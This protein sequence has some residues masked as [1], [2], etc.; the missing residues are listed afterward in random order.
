MEFF[1]RNSRQNA[2]SERKLFRKEKGVSRL[3]GYCRIV[4]FKV[5]ARTVTFSEQVSNFNA[6]LQDLVH[7]FNS[8]P[9]AVCLFMSLDVVPVFLV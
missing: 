8:L 7:H 1:C 9:G 5:G 3:F 6:W 2:K 4:L